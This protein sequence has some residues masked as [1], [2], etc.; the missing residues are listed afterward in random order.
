MKISA[1]LP[2][3]AE[4]AGRARK[5]LDQLGRDTSHKVLSTIELLVSELVANSPRHVAQDPEAAVLLEIDSSRTSVHAEI[6]ELG[7]GEAIRANAEEA[8][9]TAWDVVLLQ[10]LSSRWGVIEGS[11][12]GVWF[13]IDRWSED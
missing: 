9:K 13:E 4:G 1:R 11:N 8:Q 7:T 3:G 2:A 12:D 6:I 5:V 10:E